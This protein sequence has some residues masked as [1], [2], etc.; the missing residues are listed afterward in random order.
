MRL[1]PVL[2][3]GIE[4]LQPLQEEIYYEKA[5]DDRFSYSPCL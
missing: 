2:L 4:Q 1:A 5:I 3:L